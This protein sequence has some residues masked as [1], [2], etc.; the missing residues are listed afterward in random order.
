M[1]GVFLVAM[2]G[3]LSAPAA[4]EAQHVK[5][6]YDRSVDFSKFKTYSWIKGL[7]AD[8]PEVNRL[9]VEDISRQLQSKGLQEVGQGADLSIAYYSSLAGNINTHAVAYMKGVDWK[10]WGEHEEVYGPKMVEMPIAKV[11]VD[12]VDAPANKLIWR[13]SASDA[14]TPNEARGKKRVNSSVAKMFEKFPPPPPK[15]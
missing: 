2:L 7:D 1:K 15:K 8:N 9:I 10:Q 14:Y 6:H 5:V 4:V 12:I 11:V 13:G 3:L